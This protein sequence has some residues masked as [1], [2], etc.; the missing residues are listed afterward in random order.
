M[1]HKVLA[2]LLALFTLAFC[3]A[4]YAS[5]Y[6]EVQLAPSYK[7]TYSATISVVPA[8]SPTDVFRL[9]GSSSKTI[10]VLKIFFGG[11]DTGGN[12]S[13]QNI[14]LIKRSSAGSGGTSTTATNVPLDSNNSAATAA[15]KG[16]TA[17]PTVG[18][19]VG[20]IANVMGTTQGNTTDT[21]YVASG[22]YNQCIFDADKFGQAVVLRGTAEGL[23][24]N[25]NGVDFNGTPATV[26]CTYVWT[27]E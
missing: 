5:S 9:S 22:I 4:A 7:A 10:K 20:T 19:S 18:S 12:P 1:L 17:N 16:Y 6:G 2:S 23:A 24:V 13:A 25:M 27:E 3:P 21:I 11:T 15:L 26:N 14:F 8:S